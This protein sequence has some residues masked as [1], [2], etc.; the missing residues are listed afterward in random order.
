[1]KVVINDCHGGFDLS[2]AA[3]ARLIELGPPF[4]VI[5][6]RPMFGSSYCVAWKDEDRA[7]PAVVAVVEEL[8]PA[9]NGPHAKL[10]IVTIPDD[11]DWYIAEYGG[12]EWVAEKHRTWN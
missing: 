9:A 7:H 4:P 5:K 12:L 10:K 6:H 3:Y 1:M 8:G 11:V 2:D